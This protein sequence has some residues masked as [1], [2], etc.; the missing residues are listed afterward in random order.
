[1]ADG[2]VTKCHLCAA[3][4]EAKGMNIQTGEM[5]IAHMLSA[6][7]KSA[8]GK[9]ENPAAKSK[10]PPGGAKSCPVCRLTVKE[11]EKTGRLGCRVCYTAFASQILPAILACQHCDQHTGKVPQRATSRVRSSVEVSRLRRELER[12]VAAEE[13]EQAAELRDRINRVLKDSGT[14]GGADA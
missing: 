1:M 10:A 7:K 14:E 13:Y 12:A 9:T 5:D 3:C 8:G 4:A 11:W 6:F 2:K